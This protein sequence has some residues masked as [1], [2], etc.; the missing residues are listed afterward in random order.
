MQEEERKTLGCWSAC[1]DEYAVSRAL[2]HVLRSMS[3]W[4]LA[5]VTLT[6]G[7]RLTYGKDFNMLKKEF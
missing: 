3:K 4:E 1:L 6:G 7:F 2:K 5:E